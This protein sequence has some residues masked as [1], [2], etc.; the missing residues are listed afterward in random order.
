MTAAIIIPARY[1]SSRLS[2]K[3]LQMIAGRS[4][5]ERVWRIAKAVRGVSRVVV[6]TEDQ[7]VV[8]HAKSFG[9]EAILTPESCT[10]GTERVHAAVELAD[11]QEEIILNLQGD[12]LLTPP[13]VLEAMID[14][15]ERAPEADIVTPAVKLEGESLEAFKKH[16][17]TSPSSGSTVVFDPKHYAMYFSK[18]VIPYMRNAGSTSVYRH[19][20]LYGYRKT[21]L[22]HYVA[23][24]PTPLE[25]TE[26]LEQLR[27][28]EHGL[29]VRIAIVDYKGRTHGSVDSPED[30]AV[31]EAIIAREGELVP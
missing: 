10:N 24:P 25:K 15:I 19:I 13:W 27:A 3:P 8:D 5:L 7:R 9:A 31:A 23:L 12:A 18:S 29:K 30:V 28:L 1:G 14:E 26:G 16:K 6:A 21:G 2:G 11:V 17:L 20:G 22:D 4:M